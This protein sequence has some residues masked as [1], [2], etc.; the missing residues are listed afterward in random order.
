MAT[1]A[2]MEMPAQGFSFENCKRN[3]LLAN[4]GYKPPKVTK[5][6]TTICAVVFKDGVVLGADTRATGGS[7]VADKVC[8]KLH[9]VAPNI[10]CAGAG[11]AADCDKTTN[12]IS[13]QL[14]LHRLNTGRQ[15]PVC[16]ANR[17]VKQMLFRYQGHI[18]SYLIMGGVDKWGPHIYE[19]AAHGSTSK[20]PF[21]CMGSGTL[22][23]MSVLETGW[24]KDLEE[25]EAKQLVRDA[26]A[27]GIFNDMGSGSNVDLVVIKAND[28]VQYLRGYDEAN[29][30]GQ[31]RQKYKYPKGTTAVLSEKVRNISLTDKPGFTVI[32]EDVR[33]VEVM[34]TC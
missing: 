34:E 31:R 18:G 25:A 17:I 2:P 20:L 4:N 9:Y 23:A 16:A 12:N 21:A 28:N 30:K 13:S 10:Y 26:I 24:K 5:T 14:E 7:I 32:S 1:L 6:G 19:I 27:A 8:Q 3:A 33:P 22:P 15:V 11:T 29:V